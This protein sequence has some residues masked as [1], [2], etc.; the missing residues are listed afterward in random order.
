MS[1]ELILAALLAWVGMSSLCA[2]LERHF[3]QLW[4]RAPS[5]L[6]LRTLRAAGWMAL[7]ASLATSVAAWGWAMGP[8][9]WFGLVS[10]AGLAISL[11][12]PYAVRQPVPGKRVSR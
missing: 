7:A 11:L 12:L 3:K 5:V 2:G 9:G 4:Q 10:M 1:L 6:T 8:V